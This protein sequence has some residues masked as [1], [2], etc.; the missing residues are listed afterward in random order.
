LQEEQEQEEYSS[1]GRG[2]RTS[3]TRQGGWN[4]H[5]YITSKH[6]S[7]HLDETHSGSEGCGLEEREGGMR[8]EVFEVMKPLK[9]AETTLF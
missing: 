1:S 6:T 9:K 8:N 4:T 2:E 7:I 3:R 5:T